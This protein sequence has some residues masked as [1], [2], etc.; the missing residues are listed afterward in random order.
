M[1]PINEQRDVERPLS[2]LERWY[3]ICDQIS[4]LNVLAHARVYG[5]LPEEVLAQALDALQRRH[6]LLRTAIAADPAGRNPR[7]VSAGSRPIPLRTVTA[8][9]DPA[10]DVA[11]PEPWE[12]EVN[13]YELNTSVDWRKGPLTRATVITRAGTV[14]DAGDVH[15]L[16]LTVP[17]CIADGTTVLT[18]LQQWLELAAEIDGGGL[19]PGCPAVAPQRIL[20]APEKLLPAGHRGLAGLRKVVAQQFA[21]QGTARRRKPRRVE[22]TRRVPFE[23]RRTRLLARSLDPEQLADLV[24]A[25]RREQTTVQ[26]AL[27]AAMVTAVAQ[28]AGDRPGPMTV[29]SPITF[30]DALVPRVTEREVGTYVATVPSIVDYR[31]GGALWPMARTISRDLVRRRQRGEHLT[32]VASLGPVAPKSVAKSGRFLRFMEE[33][34]PITLCVSN[35]GRYDFP[36][37]VGQ[38]RVSHAKFIAGLS[39]NAYYCAAINTSHG[40]LAW[41][42]THV[43]GAVPAERAE[44]L[45]AGALDAVLAALK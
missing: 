1:T 32:A 21:D 10:D 20:P 37:T 6:P 8:A 39:V 26:G 15:D 33:K 43:E 30:R 25:C 42:F 44:R 18:L 16:V 2:P 27:A 3:W 38:W 24:A 31:P 35:V 22:P 14:P 23:D 12:Q 9:T 19:T 5:T 40:Q 4:P 13:D 34:G 41:N 11:G 36:H 7:F 17:H 28:D 29:G 45:T